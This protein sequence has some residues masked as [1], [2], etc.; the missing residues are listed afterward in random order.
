MEDSRP[1]YRG[2]KTCADVILYA[3]SLKAPY[4]ILSSYRPVWVF[5]V[6]RG[7]KVT[8]IQ[9]NSGKNLFERKGTCCRLYVA[10]AATFHGFGRLESVSPCQQ[11]TAGRGRMRS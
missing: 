4:K 1:A 10:P 6:Q 2:V 3:I 5:I 8:E 11:N 9:D 7:P